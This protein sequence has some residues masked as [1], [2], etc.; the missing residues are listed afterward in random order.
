MKKEKESAGQQTAFNFYLRSICLNENMWYDC[1]VTIDWLVQF[2]WIWWWKSKR[3][4][5]KNYSINKEDIQIG[6]YREKEQSS[7]P[8][9]YKKNQEPK[10][11]AS[12]RK[13]ASQLQ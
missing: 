12:Q 5:K 11:L 10:N 9:N 6:K 4:W 1:G 8:L 3:T 2:Y 7:N 13:L